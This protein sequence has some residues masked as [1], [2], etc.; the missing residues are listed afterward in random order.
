MLLMLMYAGKSLSYE[1]TFLSCI[2][3]G[4]GGNAPLLEPI[5]V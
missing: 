3:K 5:S 4:S 1:F 2:C